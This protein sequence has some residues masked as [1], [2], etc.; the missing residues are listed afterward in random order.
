MKRKTTSRNGN[1]KN[2]RSKKN[3]Q[4]LGVVSL[5][6]P[7]VRI[8]NEDELEVVESTIKTFNSMSR[9]AFK[10]FQDMGLYGMMKSRSFLPEERSNKFRFLDFAIM[11]GSAYKYE[12]PAGMSDE[13]WQKMR[14]D[15]YQRKRIRG[16]R[17]ANPFWQLDK[18]LGGPV[19]GTEKIVLQWAKDNG[20][21]TDGT[22]A[23]E[24]VL[25]GLRNHMSFE[26]KKSK[27]RTKK[28][29]PSFGDMYGR[30][31]KQVSKEEFALTRNGSITVSGRRS[32]GGNTKFKLDSENSTISLVVGRKRIDFDF[33]GSRFSKRGWKTLESLERHMSRNEIPVTFT[34]K[35]RGTGRFSVSMSYSP[36]ELSL[37]EKEN[38]E[39][40]AGTYCGIYLTDDNAICHAIYG[41]DGRRIH[42]RTYD[43]QSLSDSRASNGV[44]ESLMYKGKRKESAACAR[45]LK[46]KIFTKTSEVLDEIF[47]VNSLHRVGN[48]VVE[49]PKSR[50][51]RN[52]NRSLLSITNE[53]E[54]LPQSKLN[55]MTRSRCVKCHMR[56]AVVDGTYI[57]MLAVL[58][59]G[60]TTMR[61]AIENAT[62]QLVQRA[63]S[64]FS[65]RR[66]DWAK[67]LPD[68]SMLDWVRQLLHRKMDRAARAELRKAFMKGAV[69]KAVRLRD[70]RNRPIRED[71]GSRLSPNVPVGMDQMIV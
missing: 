35:N 49:R 32:R 20:H 66:T 71:R 42:S 51:T 36:S 25:T 19:S 2:W 4:E 38:V 13:M 64:G 40:D 70:G 43:I 50:T 10:R 65:V 53:D 16:L 54:C 61:K 69:E 17:S 22:F 15:S 6:I 21:P 24:A 12:C 3:R 14:W 7:N 44:V 33:S 41:K 5:Q 37:L 55:A 47:K 27:W 57:Q 31:K 23:H 59:S 58:G 60:S 30:S 45:H 56:M 39:R 26:S 68:P 28:D 9:C 29:S 52:F 67:I 8:K 48:V 11:D 18:D 34:L 63:K 46:N 62:F 1:T